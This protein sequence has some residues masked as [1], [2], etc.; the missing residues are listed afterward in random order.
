MKKT[1]YAT[2]QNLIEDKPS[3]FNNSFESTVTWLKT[4]YCDQKKGEGGLRLQGKYK[5]SSDNK[6]LI[7]IVT[8]VFNGVDFLEDTIK[9]IIEQN[10]D[11]VEYIVIDGGSKDGTLDIIRK[12]ESVIDYWVSEPDK[13]IYDAMNKSI[14]LASG[15]WINFMNAG[16]FFYE[17]V[18]LSKVFEK[19]IHEDFII[20]YGDHQVKYPNKIK[21]VNAGK[22]KYL[23][24]G[25]QF[26]HQSAFVN[27]S[28]HK[29]NKFNLC[30]KI[31]ADYEFFYT[32]WIV[33]INFIYL[34]LII[35]KVSSGGISDIKRI[36]SIIERWNII[37]KKL[38]INLFYLFLIL[39]EIVKNILKYK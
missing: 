34:P 22:T 2:T 31:A 12:Y 9:N 3:I 14:D 36:D 8:V 11:N 15:Q 10:Y 24:K 33:D 38:K 37:D 13:G 26:C 20:I 23:W 18:T 1:S 17:S 4:P 7:T 5:I 29:N 19:N 16:D 6:P 28:Y 32:A 30:R 35:S 39:K 25:S 27:L 21:S